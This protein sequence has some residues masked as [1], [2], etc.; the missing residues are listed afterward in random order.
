MKTMTPINPR[1]ITDRLAAGTLVR[2]EWAMAT[3]KR[4]CSRRSILNVPRGKLID[5]P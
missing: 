3:S 4:A 2:N 5:M 1:V